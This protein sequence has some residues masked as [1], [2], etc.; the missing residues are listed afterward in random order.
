MNI[1]LNLTLA[2]EAIALVASAVFWMH[3]RQSNLARKRANALHM[4]AKS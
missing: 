3:C 2:L 4:K 1:V